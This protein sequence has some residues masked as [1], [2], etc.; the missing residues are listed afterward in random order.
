MLYVDANAAFNGIWQAWAAPGTG[1]PN[2]STTVY[3]YI[4]SGAVMVGTG[5]DGSTVGELF[6]NQ[7]GTWLPL[8]YLNSQATNKPANEII[9][10][11]FNGP[12]QFFI[13]AATVYDGVPEPATFAL[14][15]AALVTLG[16]LS[17]KRSRRK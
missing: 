14:A 9:M 12:A 4:L 5:D 3:I 15:G 13:D 10:Y 6:L 11:S 17:R 7:T 16:L 1:N 2:A 8:S